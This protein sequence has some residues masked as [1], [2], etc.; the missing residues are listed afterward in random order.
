[1]PLYHL[2]PAPTSSVPPASHAP[3]SGATPPAVV[4]PLPGAQADDTTP[5][6]VGALPGGRT[7]AGPERRS[8]SRT[9]SAD[10][11]RWSR[12]AP[13]VP[14]LLDW[15][16]ESD[17]V[18]RTLGPAMWRHFAMHVMQHAS[19]RD[20]RA[21]GLTESPSARVW[22]SWPAWRRA[23][24]RIA[25]TPGRLHRAVLWWE[26]GDED[27]D[28]DATSA[29]DFRPPY[30]AALWLDGRLL[31]YPQELTFGASIAGS[32]DW[33]DERYLVIDVDGPP[34]HPGY[35]E[36]KANGGGSV[37]SLLIVDARHRTCHLLNPRAH[38]PWLRPRVTAQRG[39]WRIDPGSGD[40]GPFRL[41]TPAE[42]PPA[43]IPS[44]IPDDEAEPRSLAPAWRHVV[45][46]WNAD[47]ERLVRLLGEWNYELALDSFRDAA[48]RG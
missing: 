35:I 10:L 45:D 39:R 26:D 2:P 36:E 40:A 16:H 33:I 27:S 22:T 47:H 4:T 28:P 43:S 1:M 34:E 32:G 5:A 42:L 41:M 23:G 13:V 38:E 44:E 15:L 17:T 12:Q 31:P 20:L 48:F 37:L 19:S 29:A 25:D 3:L 7:Y 9:S 21:M 24:F 6:P 14:L 18:I 11:R 30:G 46:A 8:A